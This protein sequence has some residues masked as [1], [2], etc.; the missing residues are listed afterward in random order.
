[1]ENYTWVLML[2][3]EAQEKVKTLC[4]LI[5][6]TDKDH[7]W[8]EPDCR[9]CNPPSNASLNNDVRVTAKV[10]REVYSGSG[11]SLAT[12]TL[13]VN[14]RGQEDVKITCSDPTQHCMSCQ[15][16]I[17]STCIVKQY[18]DAVEKKKL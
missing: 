12:V 1:M 5:K 7:V 4:D 18:M 9:L 16:Y 14:N 8:G 13:Q 3:K 15:G 2:G 6:E 17:D 10:S 11:K